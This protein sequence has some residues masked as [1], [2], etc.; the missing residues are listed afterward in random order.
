MTKRWEGN[1]T[2]REACI[3][4]FSKKTGR[5]E[6]KGIDG[7]VIVIKMDLKETGCELE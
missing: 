7:R 6:D 1:C 4:Y 5:N 2:R 3:R